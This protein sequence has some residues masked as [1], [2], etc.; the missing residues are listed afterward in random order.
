MSP[1]SVSIGA[2][3]A[4]GQLCGPALVMMF[5]LGILVSIIQTATQL[6]DS[7]LP[8]VVKVLGL[9]LLICVAGKFMLTGVEDYTSRLLIAIPGIVHG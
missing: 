5:A 1:G 6:R 8:F 4:F 9:G 3:L 2:W 7:S